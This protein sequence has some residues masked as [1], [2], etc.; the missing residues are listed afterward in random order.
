MLFRGI[1]RSYSLLLITA[2]VSLSGISSVRGKTAVLFGATGGVGNDVLRAILNAKEKNDD[3]PFF[4]K[5]VMVGR[6]AFPP[7]VEDLLP[8]SPDELP[9]IVRV[10]IPN[11]EH[12]DEHELL[13]EMETDA[14]FIAVGSG[15][16]MQS[17]MHDWHSV[18]VT[19]AGSMT[20]L[21]SKMRA[22]SITMFTSVD[23]DTNPEP[24]RDEDLIQT[25]IPMGWWPVLMGTLRMMG[26]KE[27]TVISNAN[28]TAAKEIPHVRI[29]QPSD[30]ITR[31][32]RYGWFDWAV[33]K[34]H[35]VFD[36]WLPTRYH[37]VTTELLAKAM[38][39]D[40][41][42]LLSGLAAAGTTTTTASTDPDGAT[43]FTYDDFLSI[44]GEEDTFG[45][46][47]TTEL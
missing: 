24:F 4:T 31:E 13:T 22:T 28:A 35:A 37:S 1:T 46:T 30:I 15:F 6:R 9:E 5:L 12:A 41:V 45:E 26:L 42:H 25:G 32:L 7:K 27:L 11:L 44:A 29:F 43:R 10:E 2:V 39:Q 38:V 47:K 19:M 3:Y 14:C 36:P 34:F 21:C 8:Q 33:F 17:D 23:A 18:D 20:R 40:A 16:P